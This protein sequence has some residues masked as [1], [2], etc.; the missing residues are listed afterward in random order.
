[1]TEHSIYSYIPHHRTKAAADGE[2][3]V[4]VKVQDHMP[5]D[6]TYQRFNK[7]LAV[8]I[9]TNVGSMT[10]AY[11]FSVLSL[12]SLPAVLSGFHIFATVFPSALIKASL[13]A[14]IAWIA[15]TFLQ[16][17]LLPIIIVGQNV[18]AEA[19]DARAEATYNDADAVLHE[20]IK[21]QEHL[22]AQDKILSDLA[23]KL[24]QVEARTTK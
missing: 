12:L 8:A 14:L 24:A 3:G 15:Q 21:I 19:S 20:A 1:M 18:Q 2:A 22:M 10:S 7:K 17:V 13:I 4:P 6:T 5:A 9:T 11:I 23:D 16:L